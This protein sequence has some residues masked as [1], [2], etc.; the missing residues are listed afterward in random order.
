MLRRGFRL[1]QRSDLRTLKNFVTEKSG[2]RCEKSGE[3]WIKSGNQEISRRFIFFPVSA[4]ECYVK[5]KDEEKMS[6]GK[7]RTKLMME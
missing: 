5:I 3:Q 4:P 2:K 7:K 6:S 1:P